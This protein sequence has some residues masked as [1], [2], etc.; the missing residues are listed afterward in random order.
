MSQGKTKLGSLFFFSLQILKMQKNS[1]VTNSIDA[2]VI[3]CLI[4]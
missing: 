2:N 1:I 3:E 4:L